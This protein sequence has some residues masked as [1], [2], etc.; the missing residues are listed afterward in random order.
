MYSEGHGK[1]LKDFN[2]E[3][4]TIRFVLWKEHEDKV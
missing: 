1:T 3:V 4:D 2:L